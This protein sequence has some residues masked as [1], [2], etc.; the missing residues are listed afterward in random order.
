[1]YVIARAKMIFNARNIQDRLAFPILLTSADE[2]LEQFDNSK[3][4]MVFTCSLLRA[5]EMQVEWM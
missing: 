3:C 4:V 2:R 1:M 5:R